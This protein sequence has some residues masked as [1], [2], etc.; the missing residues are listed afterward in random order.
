MPLID[1]ENDLKAFQTA[2]MNDGAVLTSLGLSSASHVEKSKHIIRR[3]Y[4][5]TTLTAPGL[6]IFF[7]PGRTSFNQAITGDVL[8]IEAHVR[9]S[10][11]LKA[12]QIVKRVRQMFHGKRIGGRVW[13]FEA[14][15]GEL[16]TASGFYCAGCRFVDYK[17]I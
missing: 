6:R 5:S 10:E 12:W 14:S 8:H 2:C 16:P 7:R 9:E 1:H 17:P 15:L 11:D 4:T 13:Y 3:S